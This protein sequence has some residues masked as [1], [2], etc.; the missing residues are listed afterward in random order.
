ML[1]DRN[2]AVM[3]IR[4]SKSVRGDTVFIFLLGSAEGFHRTS[5][6]GHGRCAGTERCGDRK[7][8]ERIAT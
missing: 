1:R 2:E 5:S 6:D 7:I 8:A 3:D 4:D